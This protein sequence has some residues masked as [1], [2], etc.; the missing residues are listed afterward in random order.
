M[1]AI[2]TE[3]PVALFCAHLKA[4]GLGKMRMYISVQDDGKP[5]P[6]SKRQAGNMSSEVLL[7][8]PFSMPANSIVIPFTV[9]AK[10]DVNLTQ[11]QPMRHAQK[12]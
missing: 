7:Y 4:Q 2:D 5:K 1:Q 11:I 3:N 6:S 8:T 9:S 12:Q 10:S